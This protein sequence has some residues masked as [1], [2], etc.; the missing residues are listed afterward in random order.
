MMA[1]MSAV[2]WVLVLIVAFLAGMVLLALVVPAR[3]RIGA[4]GDNRLDAVVIGLSFILGLI[5]VG[6]KIHRG[7]RFA[8]EE[9]SVLIGIMLF[10]RLIP[11]R[12]VYPPKPDTVEEEPEEPVPAER[13]TTPTER[14]VEQKKLVEKPSEKVV[15][16]EKE[17]RPV[18][19]E[20]VETEKRPV[21]PSA[22]EPEEPA[23]EES[24]KERID[25]IRAFWD[26]WS[27]TAKEI[28][29]RLWGFIRLRRLAFTGR[30]GL[31]DPAMTGQA[32]AWITGLHGFGGRALR[33]RVAGSFDEVIVA[34]SVN[35]IWHLSMLKTWSAVAY[36]GWTG[37]K[38]W[39][40]KKRKEEQLED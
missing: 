25:Q 15:K 26:E 33:I 30:V 34:G 5:G 14:P 36:A 32:L 2:F 1:V 10:Q 4:E 22:E 37:Y 11:I 40:R 31:D 24:L 6:V 18:A 23:E 39:R 27:P 12:K 19:D 35:S 7:T 29:R 21:L 16:T 20:A 13:E 3:I 28:I 8:P 17:P 38:L 9:P